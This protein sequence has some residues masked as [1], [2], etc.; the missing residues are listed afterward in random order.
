MRPENEYRAKDSETY[1]S[2]VEIGS[3]SN[4]TSLHFPVVLWL[5]P[6]SQKDRVGNI[7]T[8][9]SLKKQQEEPQFDLESMISALGKGRVKY[10]FVGIRKQY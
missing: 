2:K 1:I 8:A 10:T 3:L 6:L 4:L 9:S 5:A 7:A